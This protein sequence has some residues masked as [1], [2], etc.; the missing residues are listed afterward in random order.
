MSSELLWVYEGLADYLSLVL[1]VRSG[2]WTQE[3]FRGYLGVE[4]GHLEYRPGR[5]WRS[6]ADTSVAAQLLF[7]ARPEGSSWRRGV[8]FYEEGDLLWLEADMLIRQQTQGRKTLD[9]FCKSFFGGQSGP[10]KVVPY[11]LDD[12]LSALKEVAPCDWA[13][14]F[15]ERVYA[16]TAHPPL[17]GLELAGWRLV[18]TN[19]APEWLEL[20][21]A[22]HNYM[23]FS[24]S[25]GLVAKG[26]GYIS[27]VLPG[28]PAHEAGLGVAMKLEAVNGQDWTPANLCEAVEAAARLTGPISL[29]VRNDNRSETHRLD[30]HGGERYPVLERI[31]GRPDLL[32]DVL[33]PRT[34][35]TPTSPA[36]GRVSPR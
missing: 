26:D 20:H 7:E 10:P 12:L 34:D 31:P 33:K 30:Y 35:P 9:D 4:A 24:F 16:V 23:D 22:A 5:N 25:L 19:T 3:D 2:L 28:S 13:T 18:Y 21:Q 17:R 29:S 11:T 27:D 36:E 15:R 8:D 14:F 6:L 1:T 32:L